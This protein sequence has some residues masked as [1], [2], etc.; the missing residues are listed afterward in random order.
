MFGILAHRL[1]RVGRVA[2]QVDHTYPEKVLF[3]SPATAFETSEA[4]GRIWP[5]Q[6]LLPHR[7]VVVM[8]RNRIFLT[9]Q[10][11]SLFSLVYLMIIIA[12]LLLVLIAQHGLY[13]LPALVAGVFLFQRRPYKRQISM[14]RMTE[15]HTSPVRSLTGRH[16][17]LTIFLDSRSVNIIPADP[18]PEEV[19]QTLSQHVDREVV[20]QLTPDQ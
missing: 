14:E 6:R 20:V 1:N 8:T 10:F 19:I 9:A 17:L 16:T 18:L 12:A 15:I 7:G 5:L 3:A 11:W 2:G 13:L 4:A